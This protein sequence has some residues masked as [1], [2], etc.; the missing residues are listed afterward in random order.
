MRLQR[1]EAVD[2]LIRNE[3]MILLYPRQLVRLAPI[4]EEIYLAAK[5]PIEL[6]T[7][8]AHLGAVF[9][10]PQGRSLREATREVALELIEQGVLRRLEDQHS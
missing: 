1:V 4:G 10:A 8:A 2:T 6:G 9:G 5:D 7:L 3:G